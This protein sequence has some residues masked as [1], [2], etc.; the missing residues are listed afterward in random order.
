MKTRF[1]Y[2][3]LACL[4]VAGSVKGQDDGGDINVDQLA[5]AE[6][7]IEYAVSFL[8]I[9]TDSRAGAMG[10]AGVATSPD[11]NS[12]HW[13]AAKYAFIQNDMGFSLSYTPWL[14]NLVKDINLGHLSF[15]KRIDKQQTIAASLVYFSLGEIIFRN[16]FGDYNGQHSPYELSFDVAYSRKFSERISG[17]MA[18]R[19]IRSDLTGGAYIGGSESKAANA[20]AADL[21]MFYYNPNLTIADKQAELSFG[22]N[23]SNI[24]SKISYT[25]SNKDFLPTQLRL[26]PAFKYHLDKYNSITGTIDISKFLVPST[27]LYLEDES[28]NVVLD[29]NDNPVILKGKNPDVS[30]PQ[31][32]LQSFYD[33]PGGIDEELHE[34]KYSFGVEYWYLNQFAV[35]GGYFTEHQNKGNRKYFSI[36]AGLKLN[37]FKVDFSYLIPQ[38]QNNPLANT[39]RFTLGF[40]FEAFQ[41]QQKE[42]TN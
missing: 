5:G 30:V 35:R 21:S 10:D 42:S 24:G 31:G 36:G 25:E 28:G 4:V 12:M 3:L 37:V 2:V 15:F 14:S 7:T 32:M 23:I 33:A 39:V 8:T 41:Q 16:D 11:N 26:G 6:K 27:P 9:A 40:D 13:N 29:E 19:Y 17:G 34:L 18:F 20:V 38:R 22:I 1:F